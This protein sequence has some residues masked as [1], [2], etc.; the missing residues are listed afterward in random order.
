[1]DDDLPLP[2][3]EAAAFLS[4]VVGLPTKPTTLA[5]WRCKGGGPLYQKHGRL[6]RYRPSRLREFGVNRISAERRSTSEGA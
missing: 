6:V 4:E 3:E 1:M 5:K 2:P